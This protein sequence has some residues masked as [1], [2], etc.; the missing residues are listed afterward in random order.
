MIGNLTLDEY[1]QFRLWKYHSIKYLKPFHK[2]FKKETKTEMPYGIFCELLW[3]SLDGFDLDG[4][5]GIGDAEFEEIVS[6]I[7]GTQ[8]GEA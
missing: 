1:S 5:G 6:S 2:K 7:R 4:L 3:N 8:M